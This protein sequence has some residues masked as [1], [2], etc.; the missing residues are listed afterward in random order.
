MSCCRLI[1]ER[2]VR[3]TVPGREKDNVRSRKSPEIRITC[4]LRLVHL[5]EASLFHNNYY[6]LGF[7]AARRSHARGV[8]CQRRPSREFSVE[9]EY[10]EPRS[11]PTRPLI[12][13]K[14]VQGFEHRMQTA[15]K[16]GYGTCKQQK[17]HLNAEAI[18]NG[19]YGMS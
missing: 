6:D 13:T 9:V 1:S 16:A 2:V 14:K 19:R 15:S 4:I 12:R 18:Q 10:C 11:S 8:D 5:N 3:R 7:I 17:H